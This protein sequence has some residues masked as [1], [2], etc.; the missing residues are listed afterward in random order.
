M[1]VEINEKIRILFL[2]DRQV[3]IKR[4]KPTIRTLI[5]PSD[6]I[7]WSIEN[8]QELLDKP[9][10]DNNRVETPTPDNAWTF[11]KSRYYGNLML[12]FQTYPT[13]IFEELE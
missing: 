6:I 3:E 2:E 12:G 7:D 4:V 8:I 11:F 10:G 1:A 9:F 5:V 13:L